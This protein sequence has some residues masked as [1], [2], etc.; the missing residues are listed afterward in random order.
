MN[1]PEVKATQHFISKHL[2]NRRHLELW[3]PLEPLELL[4]PPLDNPMEHHP[5]S[6]SDPTLVEALG[7]SIQSTLGLVENIHR[8]P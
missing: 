6:H 5:T 8:V 2:T 3:E 4:E 1:H 7:Q